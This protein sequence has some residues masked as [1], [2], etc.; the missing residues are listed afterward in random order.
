MPKC[1]QNCRINPARAVPTNPIPNAFQKKTMKEDPQKGEDDAR[2]VDDKKSLVKSKGGKGT[3]TKS[4][5]KNKGTGGCDKD[6][7][8]G[9]TRKYGNT[10]LLLFYVCTCTMTVYALQSR[11]RIPHLAMRGK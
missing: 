11:F 1:P 6:H 10:R 9:K 8:G 2:K 3:V 5:K 7:K 4:M